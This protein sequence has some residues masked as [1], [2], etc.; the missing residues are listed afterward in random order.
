MS[1]PKKANPSFTANLTKSQVCTY[2]SSQTFAPHQIR[3]D[4]GIHVYIPRCVSLCKVLLCCLH[5][6]IRFTKTRT[7]NFFGAP[8]LTLMVFRLNLNDYRIIGKVSQSGNHERTSDAEFRPNFC[9]H[10]SN[11]FASLKQMERKI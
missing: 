10:N 7:A 5:S 6:S 2:T 11:K 8:K 9:K 4:G 3:Q 1:F